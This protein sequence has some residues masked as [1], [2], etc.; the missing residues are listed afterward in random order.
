MQKLSFMVIGVVVAGQVLGCATTLSPLGYRV[1]EADSSMVSQCT[2]LGTVEGGSELGSVAQETGMHNAKN[3]ALEEAAERG[4]TH[5][6]FEN[7]AGG[8]SSYA[9]GRAYS[10]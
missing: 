3:R 4:A 1:V 7:I 2:F 9:V 10:C 8:S 5:V 6:V